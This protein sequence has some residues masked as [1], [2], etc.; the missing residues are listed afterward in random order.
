M[1]SNEQM[2]EML[3]SALDTEDNL[4][5]LLKAAVTRSIQSMGTE[6]LVLAM[7]ALGLSAEEEL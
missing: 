5:I 2:K 4:R 7:T 1:K 6:Q 3:I